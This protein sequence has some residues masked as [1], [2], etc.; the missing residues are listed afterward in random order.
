MKLLSL[1]MANFMPFKGVVTLNFPQDPSHNVMIVFGD[2]MRGKTSLL[3]A[4][5]WALYG[6]ALGRH[7]REI[8]LHQ[9]LNTD[10]AMEGDWAVEVHLRFEAS[11]RTYDLRRRA[12][13]RA[14]VAQPTRPEDFEVT[15]GLQKDG[16]PVRSDLIAAEINQIAPEQVSRFFLFDGELLQEY[17]TLL[18]EGSEQGKRIKEAIE[19]VLGVPALVNGRDE[20]GVVLKAAQKQQTKD[21]SH[22]AGLERQAEQQALLQEKQQAFEADFADLRTK[23]DDTQTER[24][25]LDDELEA[26]HAIYKAKFRFDVLVRRQQEIVQVQK[27][28]RTERLSVVRDAW[29][30]LLATKLSIRRMQLLDDQRKLTEQIEERSALQTRIRQIKELLSTSICPTCGQDALENQRSEAGTELGTLEGHLRRLGIDQEALSRVSAELATLNRLKASGVGPKVRGL[31]TDL[32]RLDVELTKLE[33]EVEELRDQIRGYDTS[34]ISRK[35]SLRDQLLKEEGRLQQDISDRQRKIDEVKKQLAIIG[36][37]LE[38]QVAARAS[39]STS[40]V[41]VCLSLEKAFSESIERL[42][43]DLRKRVQHLATEAF[44]EMTTQKAY[45]SLEINSNYGLTIVDDTNR[46]VTVRSA[47]AEQIVALSLI[48]GLSRTGRAAGPIMM[49]TPFGRL[50]LHHRDNILR[51]LPAT[52]S[53][54]ILLVHSGE[55]RRETDLVP[56]SQRIGAVYEIREV[57]ARESR[58]ERATI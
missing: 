21:L 13:K 30:D 18:I 37:S 3:N 42:R 41:S 17:E 8:P 47:G 29:R 31:D 26:V 46:R 6:H 23:L 33:N 38:G 32:R 49:D 20:I 22:V 9:L 39:R 35:R 43:E 44:R 51:Y 12:Q 55:I 4:V 19:Q 7:L 36:K 34:E 28:K 40:M 5:R 1:T 50:D 25:R 10:A 58:I 15:V 57:N 16:M 11:G 48:D 45:K 27:D 53:Q 14:L 2:N 52:T 56:I 24:T 54:L